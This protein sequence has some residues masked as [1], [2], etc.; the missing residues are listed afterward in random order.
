MWKN[1]RLLWLSLLLVI[2]SS[3]AGN[4][5]RVVKG[6][7]LIPEYGGSFY[8]YGMSSINNLL[9]FAKHLY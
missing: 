5:S 7:S 3:S 8:Y 6:S 1:Y 9:H 4:F 2:V